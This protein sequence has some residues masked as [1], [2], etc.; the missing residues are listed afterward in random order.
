MVHQWYTVRD[1]IHYHPR[2]VFYQQGTEGSWVSGPYSVCISSF[3]LRVR[4]LVKRYIVGPVHSFVSLLYWTRTLSHHRLSNC[5]SFLLIWLR[6]WHLDPEFVQVLR[7]PR[8]HVSV[9]L[10][11]VALNRT[12]DLLTTLGPPRLT[13][14]IVFIS[15]PP[16]VPDS[17]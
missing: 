17:H 14:L 4:V 3:L 13:S 6:H 7:L 1:P 2:F 8:E 9:P 12:L 16:P 5:D 15:E 10:S 11:P